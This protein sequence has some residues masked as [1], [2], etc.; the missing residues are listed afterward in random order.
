MAYDNTGIVSKNNRKEK[1]THPDING[2]CTIDGVEY[3]ISGWSKTGSKGPFYS[4][5]FKRKEDQQAA[6]PRQ[7]QHSAPVDELDDSIPF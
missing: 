3:W 6:E 5:S 1:E 4:L 2:R 7:A